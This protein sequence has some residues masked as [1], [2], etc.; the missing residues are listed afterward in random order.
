MQLLLRSSEQVDVYL[1]G[2][3]EMAGYFMLTLVDRL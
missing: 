2:G 3:L 1:G